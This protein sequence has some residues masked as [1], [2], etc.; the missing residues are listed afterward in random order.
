MEY[1]IR[2]A[3]TH[4]DFRLPEIRALAS[5]V[6]VDIE[7]V[8]YN[9][10]SPYCVVKLPDNASACAIMGRSIL[11]KDISELWGQGK[12]YEELHADVY[13]RSKHLWANYH[14][15]TFSFSVDAFA[16]KRSQ[17]EKSKIIE[18]FKYL[19]FKGRIRMKNP[20]E[21]FYVLEEY[22][23]DAETS[24]IGTK[25]VSEPRNI[26][27]GR[28]LAKSDRDI[29]NK[30]D[31]KKRRYISTTSMD[32]ELSL[33]TANMALAAPGKV[34]YD[35]FVGT[36]SFLVAA[37][38]FGALTLGSD[39]DPRSFR[40]KDTEREK[41]EVA[42]MR[43]FKQ[44]D[45]ESKMMDLFTSDLTNT[46]LRN[47]G[48]LDGITCDPPYGV[49]EGLRVLGTR[50]GVLKE[51]VYI[52]GVAAHSKPDYI[53]PKRPYGFEA[54]QRDIL[55]F[56]ARTLVTNGRLAMWM[57]T[58]D[59]EATNFPVPMHQNLEIIN[60]STQNFNLWSRRLITY[61]RLPV[62]E[63]SDTSQGRNIVDPQGVSADELN[64]FRR[65][66]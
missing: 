24:I 2:F 5:H 9:D 65:K 53:P 28:F 52:D 46:P 64:S 56:A 10:H 57:P 63:T 42:V 61:R 31:L 3:Q 38:H 59:D 43:N 26:F 23:S 37:A 27:M 32:A 49:R 20:D 12:N 47:A 39:I 13:R 41:G 4:E 40:G 11:A 17:S 45:M 34:F 44:Y 19:D 8:S 60:V 25:K 6:G 22:V 7:I 62:G 36:G 50:D 16:G 1:L 35:P 14:E 18:S 15:V 66:V 54:L 48:I 33:V 30:H 58:S 29:I 21:Q 51:P 55:D